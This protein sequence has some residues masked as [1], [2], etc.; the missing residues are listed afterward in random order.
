MTA[1]WACILELILSATPECQ[2]QRNLMSLQTHLVSESEI[3]C[4]VH[5]S[6][7]VAKLSFSFS[8]L[9]ALMMDVCLVDSNVHEERIDTADICDANIFRLKIFTNHL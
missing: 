4:F 8:H 3:N 5:Y 2:F 7:P 1:G 9:H 6:F